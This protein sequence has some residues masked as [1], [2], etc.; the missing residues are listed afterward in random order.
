VL[1]V[2]L[3]PLV[4]VARLVSGSAGMTPRGCTPPD[5]EEALLEKQGEPSAAP[6]TALPV[7]ELRRKAQRRGLHRVAGVR[8][9]KARRAALLAALEAA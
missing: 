8:A 1:T 4:V 6:L 5:L 3:L 7:A 2:L 9:S